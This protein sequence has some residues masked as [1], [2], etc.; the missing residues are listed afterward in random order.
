M[1]EAEARA[2]LDLIRGGKRFATRI[3]EEGWGLETAKGGKFRLWSFKFEPDG[4]ENKSDERISEDD[5]IARL[6]IY[7]FE[8]IKAGLR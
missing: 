4:T 3:Q 6:K 8:R 5:A 7:T 2:I 1:T